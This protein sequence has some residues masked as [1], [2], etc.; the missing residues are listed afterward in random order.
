MMV[1]ENNR[2]AY[3]DLAK[4]FCIVLV[5]LFHAKG[6]LNIHYASDTFLGSFRLPL[7]FFLSGLFFKDYGGLSKFFIKKTNR[8]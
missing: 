5:V 1:Y 7:Y 2:I 3:I 6:V 8:L 4:G